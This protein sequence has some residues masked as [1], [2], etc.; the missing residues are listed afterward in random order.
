MSNK[1]ELKKRVEEIMPEEDE[2]DTKGLSE[3]DC[4]SNNAADLSLSDFGALYVEQQNLARELKKRK[5]LQQ[6]SATWTDKCRTY[7]LAPG[8]MMNQSWYSYG[9]FYHTPIPKFNEQ[10][11]HTIR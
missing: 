8:L 5:D 10:S 3:L 4:V 9:V 6:L 11:R 2:S 1:T 7:E